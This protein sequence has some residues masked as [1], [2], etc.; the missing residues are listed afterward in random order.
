MVD[1]AVVNNDVPAEWDSM[2]SEQ[3]EEYLK[4][5]PGLAVNEP[6]VPSGA[7][8]PVVEPDG[9]K[10]ERIEAVPA[11]PAKFK[12]TPEAGLQRIAQAIRVLQSHS[13][14]RVGGG[15]IGEALELLEQGYGVLMGHH[16]PKES[17]AE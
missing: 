1:E 12:G 9:N 5:H 15:L 16:T 13:A 6:P 17:P 11:V 8:E 4:T 10:I 14:A 2:T 3:K 7:V